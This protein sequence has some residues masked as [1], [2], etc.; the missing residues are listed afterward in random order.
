[1]NVKTQGYRKFG[2]GRGYGRK[3]DMSKEEK[4][5]QIC[6][7]CNT[8]GHSREFCFKLIGYPDWFKQLS[9]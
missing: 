3:F 8:S 6:T 1:M 7:H 2:G 5:N 9:E 4:R